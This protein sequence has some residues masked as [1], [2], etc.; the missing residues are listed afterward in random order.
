[1]PKNVKTA[2]YVGV[3]DFLPFLPCTDTTLRAWVRAGKFP[4]PI[5]LR[6]TRR[7]WWR[8]E[9]VNAWLLDNGFSPLPPRNADTAT[10]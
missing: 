5:R 9:E 2:L 3:A 1:M 10:A 6:F 8:R 4:A 7:V